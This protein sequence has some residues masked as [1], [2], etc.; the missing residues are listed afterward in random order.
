SAPAAA[1]RSPTRRAGSCSRWAARLGKSRSE[2]EASRQRLFESERNSEHGSFFASQAVLLVVDP[3]LGR[4]LRLRIEL[5]SRS[6]KRGRRGERRLRCV[7]QRKRQLERGWS[8]RRKR[9]GEQWRSA[10]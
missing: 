1:I 7:Q 3:P 6:G 2:R 4:R 9:R 10:G 5:R 8:Q